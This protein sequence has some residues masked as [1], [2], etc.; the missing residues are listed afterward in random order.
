MLTDE[1]V[2]A[3]AGL[4]FTLGLMTLSPNPRKWPIDGA[5]GAGAGLGV[6]DG[7]A[8]GVP[9]PGHCAA[10]AAAGFPVWRPTWARC[11]VRCG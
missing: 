7:D 8:R 1:A 2:A 10:D 9:D 5:V 11:L 3:G 4:R 6:H